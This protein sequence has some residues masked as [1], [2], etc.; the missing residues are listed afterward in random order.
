MTSQEVVERLDLIQA[1]LRL[2]FREELE[3]AGKAI[4]ADS[5]NA[6]IL[7]TTGD[8]VA[9]KKLQDQVAKKAKTSTRTVR[10]RLAELVAQ[11]VLA[12]RGSERALEYRRT[13]LI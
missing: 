12:S 11:R 4:R 7:D 10:A 8:W 1:T 5:V 13:G 9:S 3:K 6:A 2:A